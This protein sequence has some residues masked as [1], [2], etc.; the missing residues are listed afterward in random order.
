MNTPASSMRWAS[1]WPWSL[2]PT[3]SS[4]SR[5]SRARLRPSGRAAAR[6]DHRL[7]F[8]WQGRGRKA[9]DIALLKKAGVEV[10]DS[11]VF[12][13]YPDSGRTPARRARSPVQGK[14]A[15]EIRVTR[16]TVV[17]SGNGYDFQVVAQEPL[18]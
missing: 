3:S 14:A 7:Y 15:G 16:F 5:I 9:S 4:M 6:G 12:Q 10:G 13:F 17:P 11:V 8:L 1:R 18:R 2:R